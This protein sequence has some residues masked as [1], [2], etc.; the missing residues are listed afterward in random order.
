MFLHEIFDQNKDDSAMQYLTGN[1]LFSHNASIKARES[2][3]R[4]NKGDGGPAQACKYHGRRNQQVVQKYNPIDDGKISQITAWNDLSVKH[5][6][7]A[8]AIRKF[9]LTFTLPIANDAQH[10]VFSSSLFFRY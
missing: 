5:E 6:D 3:Q 2:W 1:G 8:R 4:I 7:I 9:Y 10:E